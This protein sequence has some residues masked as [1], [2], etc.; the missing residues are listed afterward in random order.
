MAN[1]EQPNR[2]H[3]LNK[4]STKPNILKKG[5][6]LYISITL[7]IGL[8]IGLIIIRLFFITGENYNL[9]HIPLEFFSISIAWTIFFIAWNS[10]RFSDSSFFLFIGISFL[11]I[12]ALDLIHTLIYEGLFVDFSNW[13]T[14]FWIAARYIHAISFLAAVF[15]I[16]KRVK[17]KTT[18]L[19]YSTTFI[20]LILTIFGGIF[21]VCYDDVYGKLTLFKIVS[22]YIIISILIISII[23]FL[24]KRKAF[25]LKM[26]QMII[27]ALIFT[28]LSEYAFTLYR[29]VTGITNLVGHIFKIISFYWIYKG[30]IQKSLNEPY[31][32]LFRSLQK[33]EKKYRI[34]IE[35]AQEGIWAI[36]EKANTTFVNQHMADIL[37]YNIDEMIGKHL[38]NFMDNEDVKIAR[39]N[40]ERRRSGIKETIVFKFI[41]KDETHIY[42]RLKVAPLLDINGNYIGAIAYVTDITARKHAEEELRKSEDKFKT[43]FNSASDS[44][45]IHDFE[46]NILEVNQLACERLDYSRDELL[47]MNKKSITSPEFAPKVMER[48]KELIHS[49][50]VIST[51]E[52]VRRDGTIIPIEINSNIINYEGKSAILSIARDISERIKFEKMRNQFVYTVSHELRTPVSVILQSL[53]NLEKYKE[54]LS[55]EQLINLQRSIS[56]NAKLLGDL[57]EDLLLISRLDEKKI[58]LEW[59]LYKPFNIL[60]EV[61]DQLEPYQ[62]IKNISIDCLVNQDIQLFGDPKKISQIFRIFIDNAIKYSDK[63]MK[64]EIKVT[65]HYRGKY[66]P[67]GIDGILVQFTDYGIGIREEDIPYIFER[68]FRSEEIKTIPGTGLGLSIALDLIHLHGGEI[69]VESVFGKGTSF[70]LFLPRLANR[71]L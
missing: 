1:L 38:F 5:I 58:K 43:L 25:E 4:Y 57:I 46:G 70:F 34:L 62:K 14:Q 59:V 69:Y 48:I 67:T 65:D 10:R 45:F 63:E 64:I 16:K 49:S 66:N 22:E 7:C 21:P 2:N 54:N 37:G 32:T 11:F 50:H 12:G 52:H 9:I 39:M 26:I 71:S 47:K 55:E 30:L 60:N 23:L 17:I 41:R 56:R 53:N 24:K 8:I 19:I 3:E 40:L 36:D 61:L 35:N 68:F 28:I 31:Y 15:F 29:D 44:I 51:T 6:I 42:T 20:F 13:A 18:F 27:L 33:S